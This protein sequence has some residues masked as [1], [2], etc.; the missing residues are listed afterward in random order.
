MIIKLNYGT[1]VCLMFFNNLFWQYIKT[2]SRILFLK[3]H[4]DVFTSSASQAWNSYQY[5]RKSSWSLEI[6][7]KG[8]YI[9]VIVK[10]W[11]SICRGLSIGTIKIPFGVELQYSLRV[12]SMRFKAPGMELTKAPFIYFCLSKIFDLAKVLVKFLQSHLYLTSATAAQLQW[13]LSN[14]NMIFSI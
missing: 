8:L 7:S 9:L 11:C 2:P 10:F 13:H 6:F 14:I 1:N 12:K 5:V 3:F 4:D